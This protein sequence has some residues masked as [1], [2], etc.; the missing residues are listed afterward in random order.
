MAIKYKKTIERLRGEADRESM[1]LYISRT[2][3][4]EFKKACEN[5]TPSRVLEELM[6]DFV[7]SYKKESKKKKKNSKNVEQIS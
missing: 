3:F 2:V 6:R 4:N 7:D 5:V 1:S